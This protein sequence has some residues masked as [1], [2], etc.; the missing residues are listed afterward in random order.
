[1]KILLQE[2][3][4]VMMEQINGTGKTVELLKN[5]ILEY[6]NKGSQAVVAPAKRF[7]C[8]SSTQ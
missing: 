4:S 8:A 7:C 3:V 2:G 1:V 6:K 5:D